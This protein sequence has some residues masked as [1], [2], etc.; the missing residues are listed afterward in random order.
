[1]LLDLF[2]HAHA[3]VLN[4]QVNVIAR[5]RVVAGDGLGI[6]EDVLGLD[7]EL[8]A[9]GHGVTRVDDEVDDYL[10]ELSDF[11]HDSLEWGGGGGDQLDVFANE[12]P[13]HSIQIEDDR[14]EI[15][16]LGLSH[17]P[18]CEGQ[19]LAAEVRSS[20]DCVLDLQ[21]IVDGGVIGVEARPHQSRVAHD[22][23]EGVVEVMGEPSGQTANSLHLLCTLHLPLQLQL[24]RDIADHGKDV[25]DF[26]ET[27]PYG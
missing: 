26:S 23:R 15:D 11:G 14:V 20:E 4:R 10:F 22:R 8:A 7:D 24:A 12:S 27:V 25:D 17:L 19:K 18:P 9:I 13:Q 6:E 16:R 3:R 1:M 21:H 2:G 5:F